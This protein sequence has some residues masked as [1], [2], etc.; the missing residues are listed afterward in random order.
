MTS[1]RESIAYKR[2]GVE[3]IR[4]K[5]LKVTVGRQVEIGYQRNSTI[6]LKAFFFF[7][8]KGTGNL[9]KKLG[10]KFVQQQCRVIIRLVWKLVCLPTVFQV[11]VKMAVHLIF[12]SNLSQSRITYREN[13]QKRRDREIR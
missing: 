10:Q 6:S 7:N 13:E 8:L 5:V 3:H 11:T 1:G 12:V 2:K 9:F 4:P